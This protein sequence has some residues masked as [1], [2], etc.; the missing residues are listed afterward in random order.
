MSKQNVETVRLA[1]AA[2][3]RGDWEEATA[4]LAP[5]VV[6]EVGQELPAHGPAAVREMWARWNDDWER[7]DMT[8]E[9]I[10]DAG[11]KVFVAMHYSGRGRLSGVAIEQWV[12]EVHTFRGDRCIGKADFE[13]RAEALAAAGLSE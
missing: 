12:F 10:V 2:Y 6:W 7:L 5:D 11:D 9:E 13:T 8:G 4:Y 1:I 3:Q